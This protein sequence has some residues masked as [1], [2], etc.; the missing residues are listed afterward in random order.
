MYKV[1]SKNFLDGMKSYT[2][3]KIFIGKNSKGH[4]SIKNVG[5]VTVLLL[6]TLSDGGLYLNKV[7]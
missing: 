3:D 1:S 5:V 2:A 7:S 6:C 4:N